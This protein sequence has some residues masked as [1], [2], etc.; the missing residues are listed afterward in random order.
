MTTHLGPGGL[1]IARADELA[2]LAIAYGEAIQAAA[3]HCVELYDGH[4]LD[5]R[6]RAFLALDDALDDLIAAL[7]VA[8][9]AEALEDWGKLP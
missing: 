1:S 8:E 2:R 6:D 5:A 7:G 3:P 9:A 4:S